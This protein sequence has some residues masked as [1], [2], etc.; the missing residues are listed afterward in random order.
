MTAILTDPR[1]GVQTAAP[2]I[3]EIVHYWES[4]RGNLVPFAAMVIAIKDDGSAKLFVTNPNG[5]Q[6][7]SPGQMWSATPRAKHWSYRP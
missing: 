7:V 5:T 1:T 4:W 3:G 2:A 6:F